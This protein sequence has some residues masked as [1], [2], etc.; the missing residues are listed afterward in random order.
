MKPSGLMVDLQDANS[1]TPVTELSTRFTWL[2]P[3]GPG[4]A[5]QTAFQIG[6]NS[7]AQPVV[8]SVKVQSTSS[9]SVELKTFTPNRN[10]T[11]TF[12]VRCWNARAQ[13]SDW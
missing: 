8:D 11:Y 1:G 2:L 6:L 4:W 12:K 13:A 3:D 10:Q 9:V 5:K 7:D